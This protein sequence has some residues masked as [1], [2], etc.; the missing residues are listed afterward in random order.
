MAFADIPQRENGQ[1]I[2]SSWFNTIRQ[3]LIDA[4]DSENLGQQEVVILNNQASYANIT[5][6]ILD[7]TEYISAIIRYDIFR[8]TDVPTER[9]EMGTLTCIWDS[10]A[11]EWSIYRRLDGGTDTLNMPTS[12]YVNPSTGQMQYKTDFMSG[13]THEGYFRY[14]I[15]TKFVD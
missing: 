9:R 6:F 7:S 11:A 10:T 4:F 3:F 15:I 13:T 1:E 12:L 14:K 8:V 2:D 5:D